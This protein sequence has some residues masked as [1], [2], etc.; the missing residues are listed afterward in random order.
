[1]LTSVACVLLLQLA[2]V[3]VTTPSKAPQQ[4]AAPSKAI[5]ASPSSPGVSSAESASN[6]PATGGAAPKTKARKRKKPAE[7]MSH[8]RLRRLIQKRLCPHLKG[9]EVCVVRHV[10]SSNLDDKMDWTPTGRLENG[11]VFAYKLNKQVTFADYV[12]DV[13]GHTVSAC[14]H[15][16]L[17]K[18]RESVDDHLLVC[19]A[20]SD[21]ERLQLGVDFTSSF[22][23]YMNAPEHKARKR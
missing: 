21:A 2:P 7:R 5:P 17:V 14:P 12:A 3:T 15:I 1:M 11:M 23:N 16:F 8:L 13:M 9:K 6:T 19:D 18:T 20:F 22:Q 4:R 10:R